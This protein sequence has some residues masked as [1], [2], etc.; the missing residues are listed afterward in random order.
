MLLLLVCT[1]CAVQIIC[2]NQSSAWSDLKR[3]R[4][5]PGECI[6]LSTVAHR[7]S[8][9][10]SDLWNLGMWLRLK[11]WFLNNFLL[12]WTIFKSPYW[13]CYN[14]VSVLC[15]DCEVCGILAP[16]QGSVCAGLGGEVL[17]TGK[18]QSSDFYVICLNLYHSVQM[19]LVRYLL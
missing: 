8:K 14:F 17:T 13:V 16:G 19:Y 2:S 5:F 3:I 4:P 11:L 15:S 18:F 6:S 10:V 1:I 7:I 12:M 9:L